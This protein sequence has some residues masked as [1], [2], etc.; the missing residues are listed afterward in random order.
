MD[1][2]SF[3]RS[4]ETDGKSSMFFGYGAGSKNLAVNRYISGSESVCSG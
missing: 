4:E 1:D 3:K 2:A